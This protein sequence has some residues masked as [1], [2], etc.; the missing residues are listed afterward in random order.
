MQAIFVQAIERILDACRRHNVVPSAHA[1]S[2][3]T[4]RKRIEQGFLM[5]EMCDGAG[6]PVR[7]ATA[8]LKAL[9]SQAG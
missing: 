6:A 9:R 5:V 2:V 8:N 7:T 3:A 4:A 1:G